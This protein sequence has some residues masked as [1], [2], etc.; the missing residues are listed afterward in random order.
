MTAEPLDPAVIMAIR[1]REEEARLDGS[2]SEPCERDRAALLAEVDRLAADL[3]AANH[4]LDIDI[5]RLGV[6]HQLLAAERDKVRRVEALCVE[7]EHMDTAAAADAAE[8]RAAL[9]GAA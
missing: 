7:W 6:L 5:T 3:V 9:A 4:A 8:V 1:E 2:W